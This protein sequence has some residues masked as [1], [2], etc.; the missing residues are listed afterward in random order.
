MV[1]ILIITIM[2]LCLP[3]VIANKAALMDKLLLAL[4][5]TQT[6]FF[7]CIEEKRLKSFFLPVIR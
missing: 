4:E 3:K 6:E 5:D 1:L 7:H 2:I